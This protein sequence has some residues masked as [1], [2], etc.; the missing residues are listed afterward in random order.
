[1]PYGNSSIWNS[2]SYNPTYGT[3]SDNDW[4]W[5]EV[6]DSRYDYDK[7]TYKPQSNTFEISKEGELY[8][9]ADLYGATS[10]EIDEIVK[11]NPSGTGDMLH[12]LVYAT[13]DEI[14]D[15]VSELEQL[16]FNSKGGN[17]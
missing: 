8:N 3:R 1:M 15:S 10:D 2:K 4:G 17:K 13:Q 9:L 7:E 16:K 5:D 6:Y 14:Y 11:R 12:D